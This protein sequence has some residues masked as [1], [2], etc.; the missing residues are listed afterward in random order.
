MLKAA[1]GPGQRA[2][3]TRAQPA[4][5]HAPRAGPAPTLVTVTAGAGGSGSAAYPGLRVVTRKSC[6]AAGTARAAAGM[7]AVHD[8]LGSLCA[9]ASARHGPAAPTLQRRAGYLGHPNTAAGMLGGTDSQGAF[10]L[11]T[12]SAM[13]SAAG[14]P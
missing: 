6:G 13:C 9:H 2:T 4:S 14:A 8:L 1:S 7:L 11:L 5:A 12:E 3:V 10:L